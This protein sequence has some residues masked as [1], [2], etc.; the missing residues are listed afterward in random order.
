MIR[1]HS[2][3]A[4]NMIQF[5]K[6]RPGPMRPSALR[7]LARHRDLAARCLL[8]GAAL[9]ALAGCHDR[10][11]QLQSD[12]F[13]TPAPQS[14]AAGESRDLQGH[15][16]PLPTEGVRVDIFHPPVAPPPTEEQMG[17]DSSI[18]GVSDVVRE[19]VQSPRAPV[20]TP[21]SQPSI[22]NGAATAPAATGPQASE[23]GQPPTTRISTEGSY[24]ELGALVVNVNGTP[25]YANKVLSAVQGALAAQARSLDEDHFRLAV[26]D[27][28]HRR[29]DTLVRS[30]LEFAIAQ[31]SLSKED[32][33]IAERLTEKWREDQINHAGGSLEV[34]R[35]R[36]RAE[37]AD[38]EELVQ[39]NYRVEMRRVYFQKKEF[40]RIQI[41]ANDMRQYYDQNKDKLFS[42]PDM[43]RFRVIKISTEQ[44]GSEQLADQ[45]IH[46]IRDKVTH[47]QDFA[48][49]AGAMNS[50]PMLLQNKGD[51]GV[52]QPIAR[53][54]F[55]VEQVDDAVWKL[56]PGQ[57]TQVIRVGDDFYLAKLE[58]KTPGHTQPFEDD[59]VQNE[60]RRTLEAEQFQALREERVQELMR[61][62]IIYPDPPFYTPVIEMAMEKYPEWA[63]RK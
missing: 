61:N 60:I 17:Q 37:G 12:Q 41:T 57:V 62:A 1:S 42:E 15:P 10:G 7:P 4:R 49:L 26:E 33:D 18:N 2:A 31:R 43:G 5:R 21:A 52:G 13:Y 63:A 44:A 32:K 56:K 34:A 25:I 16:N 36:A 54:S 46:E 53:G 55:V 48:Q 23:N 39:E 11:D 22:F 59:A 14:D 58:Q 40:P 3:G 47:G 38:F 30:E 29:V 24:L 28:V 35:Q 45:Q 20:L 9:A 8:A 6:M 27:E 50:D 19:A 51:V